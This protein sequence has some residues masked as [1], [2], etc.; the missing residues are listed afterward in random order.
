MPRKDPEAAR[1]YRRQYRAANREKKRAQSLRHY[2][3][4]HE[5]HKKNARD[6]YHASGEAAR[7]RRRNSLLKSRRG[8]TVAERGNMLNAQ[9]NV[10]VICGT[11]T[12]SG[13]GWNVDHCH[14]TGA[15][16]GILCPKCNMAIGLLGHDPTI[17]QAAIDYLKK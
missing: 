17:L 12:P 1:E 7:E 2:Y 10:C 6:R 16:R 4:Y 5:L 13:K 3:K 8:I 9:G 15:I 14:D 11:D